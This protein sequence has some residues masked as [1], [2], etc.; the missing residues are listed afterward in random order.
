[1][2]KAESGMERRK[3]KDNPSRPPLIVRGGENVQYPMSKEGEIALGNWEFYY[4]G[5]S[6]APPL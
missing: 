1:M 4:I 6:D 3:E 2:R 5:N